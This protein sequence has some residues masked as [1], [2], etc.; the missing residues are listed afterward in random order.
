MLKGC[1]AREPKHYAGYTAATV[2]K[3]ISQSV[4]EGIGKPRNKRD[5]ALLLLSGVIQTGCDLAKLEINK[6]LCDP[7][8]EL[9]NTKTASSAPHYALTASNHGLVADN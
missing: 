3:A 7:F 4:S 5:L 9:D 8:P 1:S 2:V 6:N